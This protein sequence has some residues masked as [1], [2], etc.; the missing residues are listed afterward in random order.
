M[1]SAFGGFG[2]AQEFGFL[3]V[4]GEDLEAD[5]EVLCTIKIGGAAGHGNAGDAGKVGGEREDVG[6]I[7]VERVGGAGADFACGAWCDR[8]DDRV[9]FLEGVFEILADERADFLGTA[10]VGVVVA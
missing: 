10:V 9:D 6:E 5:G 1:R 7:F 8:R 4:G 2:D 3:E